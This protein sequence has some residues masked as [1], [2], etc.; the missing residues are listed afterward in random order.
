MITERSIYKT[1]ENIQGITNFHEREAATSVGDIDYYEFGFDF[2]DMKYFGTQIQSPLFTLNR[3]ILL[4]AYTLKKETTKSNILDAINQY[5]L[6]RPLI[7]LSLRKVRGKQIQV[8]FSS[9]FIADDT[10][11]TER[12]IIPLINILAPSPA[13]FVEFLSHKKISLTHA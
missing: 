1:L 11:I 5:N 2:S 4:F 3:I 12:Q 6:E 10:L 8:T 9:D 13:D 7:K